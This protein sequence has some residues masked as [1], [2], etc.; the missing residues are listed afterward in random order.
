VVPKVALLKF[1][2]ANSY[3][4]NMRCHTPVMSV[5]D[6]VQSVIYGLHFTV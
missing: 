2:V 4:S 5:I 3:S 6:I 1:S